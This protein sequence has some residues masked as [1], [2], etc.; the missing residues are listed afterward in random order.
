MLLGF[1][2]GVFVGICLILLAPLVGEIGHEI[3]LCRRARC[4]PATKLGDL[5]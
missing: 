3:N 5:S 4:W 2:I 1:V